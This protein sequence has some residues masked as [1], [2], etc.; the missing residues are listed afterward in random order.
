MNQA[1]SPTGWML[2]KELML[3]THPASE[4]QALTIRV[5]GGHLRVREDFFANRILAETERPANVPVDEQ[6]HGDN[7]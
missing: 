1:V 5:V 3:S 2:C 7:F 4:F 6:L